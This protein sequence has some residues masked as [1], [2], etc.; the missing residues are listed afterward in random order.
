MTRNFRRS[1]PGRKP[2]SCGDGLADR[3]PGSPPGVITRRTQIEHNESAFG[4]VATSCRRG[5]WIR[6][7]TLGEQPG[8]VFGLAG[9]LIAHPSPVDH[10]DSAGELYWGG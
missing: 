3:L 7:A 8:K 10:P 5:Q 9:G 4:C 2:V 1:M 6:F